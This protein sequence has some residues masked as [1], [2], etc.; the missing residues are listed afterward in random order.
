MAMKA[1]VKD[2]TIGRVVMTGMKDSRWV[3]WSKLQYSVTTQNGTKG[4]VHYVGKFE[5]G[6]LK[7]VDDF[8]FK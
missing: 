1:V 4:V 6:V 7:Y 2:P 3:G 5:N 8:K